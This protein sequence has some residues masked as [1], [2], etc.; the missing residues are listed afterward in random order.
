MTEEP[1]ARM[2]SAEHG[3]GG[4]ARATGDVADR[5]TVNEMGDQG[6]AVLH[7]QLLQGVPEPQPVVLFF[8]LVRDEPRRRDLAGVGPVH[9]IKLRDPLPAPGLPRFVSGYGVNPSLRQRLTAK[10]FAFGPGD[11]K[12]PGRDVLGLVPIPDESGDALD[13]TIPVFAVEFAEGFRVQPGPLL[14]NGRDVSR[15]DPLFRK[16]LIE[17]LSGGLLDDPQRFREHPF[18]PVAARHGIGDRTIGLQSQPARNHVGDELRL[19]LP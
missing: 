19:C 2:D 5:K 7:R 6:A 4:Y 3:A 14:M 15:R 8:Q 13:Q 17:D 16:Q 12:G 10:L 18:V 11:L 9:G 1:L